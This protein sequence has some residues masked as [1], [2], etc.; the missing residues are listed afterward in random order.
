[1]YIGDRTGD[2][3]ERTFI[4]TPENVKYIPPL[5]EI[6]NP[7]SGINQSEWRWA[8]FPGNWG[9]PLVQAPLKLWCLDISLNRYVECDRN[10]TTIN[11]VYTIVSTLEISDVIQDQEEVGSF[12]IQSVGNLTRVPYPDITGPLFRGFSY[13]YV[14]G[15]PAP[16]LTQELYNMTCPGDVED[17]KSIPTPGQ[18]DA[19]SDTI[20]SY[21][22]GIVVGTIIF[23]II[24]IIL[25]ALPVILDKTGNVQK[26]VATK[27]KKYKGKV[28]KPAPEGQ[29]TD[30][31][32]VEMDMESADETEDSDLRIDSQSSS[33]S[34]YIVSVETVLSPGQRTRLIVWG[35]FA[36]ALFIAGITLTFIG[37]ESMF[38]N[39]ILTVARDRLGAESLVNTLNWLVAGLC[40]LIIVTDILMFLVIFMFQ[41]RRISVGNGRTIWN[42][43][44]GR[45]WFMSKALTILSIIVGMI[46][47]IVAICA[48]LFALALVVT[49][50]QLVARVGCNEIFSIQAFG[51]SAQ[52]ICLTIPE[53]GI[54]D[55]C[56]WEALQVRTA[57]S[58]LARPSS[59]AFMPTHKR[60]LPFIM[61]RHAER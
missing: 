33:K 1:V 28:T 41:G 47:M 45:A 11:A 35:A 9:A 49:L 3:P 57:A 53:L 21:L 25:L 56:G 29:A 24:L 2:D 40:I 22:I 17:L 38:S 36:S 5:W 43:L 48:V 30:D 16:I 39:S 58:S 6:Q 26:Y 50:A 52:S 4:P 55:V 10:S 46:A 32:E 54:N 51:Q 31:A 60:A 14:A 37:I 8:E 42:P 23:S 27:Y 34:E 12:A 15:Q 18:L 13:E 61:R 20:I 59:S 7:N 19:S 44:G